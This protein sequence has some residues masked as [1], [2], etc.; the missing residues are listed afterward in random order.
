MAYNNGHTVFTEAN[1]HIKQGET[2]ALVAESG[3]GKS[4]AAKLL[5]RFYDPISGSIK[6]DGTDIRQYQLASMRDQFAIILQ[7]SY[8]FNTSVYDNISYGKLDSTEQEIIAAAKAARAH[9]FIEALPEGYDTIISEGGTSLSG[10][11]RQRIA[12]ARAIIRNAP[13]L[14]LDEPTSSLDR[15]NKNLVEQAL[16]ALSRDRTCILITHDKAA[17]KSA[18]RV[19]SLQEGKF[20]A[21]DWQGVEQIINADIQGS[22]EN[23][24]LHNTAMLKKA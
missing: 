15:E 24:N 4:T 1:L 23:I 6:I 7:H 13:I 11:Q 17:A 3:E 12:I 18:D 10:G 22:D 20:V 9:N 14:I 16:N 21:T 19:V 2:V 5:L 8:L